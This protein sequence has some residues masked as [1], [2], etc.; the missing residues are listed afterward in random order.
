MDLFLPPTA[1][2]K[3]QVGQKVVAAVTILAEL[4]PVPAH[5][6]AELAAQMTS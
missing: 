3:V 4:P 2:V 5:A 1:I 6:Q